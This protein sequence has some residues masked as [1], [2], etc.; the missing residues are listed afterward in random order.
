M[1]YASDIK[2]KMSI[3]LL[4]LVFTGVEL[5]RDIHI[6]QN[7]PKMAKISTG[8]GYPHTRTIR[9]HARKDLSKAGFPLV[10]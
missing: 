3:N 7:G 1:T 10:G 5:L 9:A 4:T 8:N 6:R 2:K